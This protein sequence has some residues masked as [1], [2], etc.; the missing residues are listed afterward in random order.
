MFKSEV[1]VDPASHIFPTL[2]PSLV[3]KVSNFDVLSSVALGLQSLTVNTTFHEQ[4]DNDRNHHQVVATSTHAKSA[5]I[6]QQD[7]DLM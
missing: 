7:R 2:Q 1:K 6:P 3:I 4:P 5:M